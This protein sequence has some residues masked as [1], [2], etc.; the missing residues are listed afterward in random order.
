MF[1][2]RGHRSLYGSLLQNGRDIH[3]ELDQSNCGFKL[4][5]LVRKFRI[6]N[7]TSDIRQVREKVLHTYLV[8]LP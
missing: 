6:D 4:V 7:R 5:V 1:G 3:R 8:N 2:Q